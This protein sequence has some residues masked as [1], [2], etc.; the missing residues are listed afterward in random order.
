M[1]DFAYGNIQMVSIEQKRGLQMCADNGVAMPENHGIG[2]RF[3]FVCLLGLL[4][5]FNISCAKAEE[6]AAVISSEA[7]I[8][9]VEQKN[10]EL[11]LK[12]FINGTEMVEF[13]EG[14]LR[15]GQLY[16][17]LG[18]ISSLLDFPITVDANKKTA[19]GWF[20][21]EKNKISLMESEAIASGEKTEVLPENMFVKDQDLF[22]DSRLL[23]KWFPMDFS[24][25]IQNMAL[26]ITTHEALPYEEARLRKKLHA[27]LAQKKKSSEDIEFKDIDEPYAALQWPSVDL[28]V[29]SGY[30]SEGKTIGTNYSALAVGDF[31][32][33]TGRLYAAG[34]SSQK[35]LSDIRL[36]FGRD[37]YEHR[38]LGPAR[39]SSFLFGDINSVSLNQVSSSGQGR[40]FMMTNRA[41][42][43]PDKFDVTSFI[44]DSKPGWEI[45]LYRN[46]G[47]IDFQTV[48]VNGRYE[49]KDVPVLF[50]NNIFRL[51]F[52][53]PQGQRE[54]ISKTI[55]ADSSL[56]E[57]GEFTYNVSLDQKAKSLFA[58]ASQ[59][60]AD[61]GGLRAVGELE[62]G[63]HR[64]LTTTMGAAQ[65]TIDEKKHTYAT[66]GLHSSFLGLLTAL[67][68]A[69]DT[70]GRGYSAGL[71]ASTR[72]LDT[73]IRFHQKIA[74]DFISEADSTSVVSETG[75]ELS[76]GFNLP[77]IGLIDNGLGL[78]RKKYS[79]NRLEEIINYRLSKSFFG[80][81]LTNALN[82]DH[83][84]QGASRL[85]GALTLHTAYKKLQL[86]SQTDYSF[87][88]DKQI[89]KIKI[90]G[91]F[92]IARGVSNTVS[93]VD[94]FT[95]AGLLQLENTVTFDK[96]NYKLSLTGRADNQNNFFVGFSVN[97]AIGKVP[98]TGGWL[99]SSKSLAGTGT[100]A[101]RPFIDSNYNQKFDSGEQILT[102]ASITVDNQRRKT[103]NRGYVIAT[104][105][106]TGLPVT[107]SLDQDKLQDSYEQK[108][109]QTK[110]GLLASVYRV[111]PR[112]G[113]VITVDYP[114]FETSQLDGMVNVPEGS[115]PSALQVDLVN[116]E[117]QIV[118]S[119]RT[120]FDGYYLLE[121]I[122]PG[123]YKVQV[124]ADS[125]SK[126]RLR[127]AEDSAIVIQTSDMYAKDVTLENE[128][129]H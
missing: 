50:G 46:D 70:T 30:Q 73:D 40:G 67:E 13:T 72:Q 7:S 111:V 69:Y 15:D 89:K 62:Y 78:T 24:V 61:S 79:F 101:V 4:W 21:N 41:L 107:I 99:V 119:T 29:S 12:L 39:A 82:Y 85:D 87:N 71:S 23:Q 51:V 55:N 105:M 20:I 52:Y 96:Q 14:F 120:A 121:G 68:G 90:S 100:I 122:V 49:F 88:P 83:D 2:R 123:V 104:Q 56:L 118:G 53:G 37:D 94:D 31:G 77:F 97:T 110:P 116:T 115:S 43:R 57:Q 113:K 66:A 11:V 81:K 76:R 45:E 8:P 17:P 38:L 84:N 117:G 106:P 93:L 112:K 75:L 6:M 103:D 42:D 80:I 126:K 109:K 98:S 34:D 48:G 35:Y 58:V 10:E 129:E 125:L 28:T 114:L 16:L 22:I 19:E 1:C 124:A 95:G 25:E 65:T 63:V 108:N 47:L 26:H 3:F 59:P 64:R 18:Q 102:D 32:Y 36:N 60:T 5:T 33:L 91:L 86:D 92:P 44:G 9:V 27:N 128:Q 127:Q 74:K 54:E